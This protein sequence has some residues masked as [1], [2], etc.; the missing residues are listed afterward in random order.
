MD[1]L[2]QKQKLVLAVGIGIIVLMGLIPP[3]ADNSFVIPTDSDGKQ[4]GQ[5]SFQQGAANYHFIFDPPR[6]S[7]RQEDVYGSHYFENRSY[8]LDFVRL[9]LQWFMVAIGTGAGIY[10]F[11]EQT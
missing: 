8:K 5:G 7:S 3:W 2:N 6:G 11:R 10:F 1:K 4:L 9:F